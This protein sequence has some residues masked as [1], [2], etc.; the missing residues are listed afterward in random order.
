MK[1]IKSFNES[2]SHNFPDSK[3]EVDRLCEKYEI[4]VYTINDDLSIDVFGNV[5]LK[6]LNLPYIPLKFN[7]VTGTFNCSGNKLTSLEGTPREVGSSFACAQNKLTSLVGGPLRV[8]HN[9]Y[10]NDNKLTN[11]I[12]CAGDINMER[13][14][15]SIF[16][17]YNNI[18]SLE[19]CPTDI[20]LICC[21]HNPLFNLDY[22]PECHTT[23]LDMCPVNNL[24]Y[25]LT[26]FSK[27][28]FKTQNYIKQLS[29]KLEEFEVVK[30]ESLDLISLNSLFDYYNIPFDPN[31]FRKVTSYSVIE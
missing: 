11:L 12:G 7:K 2:Q 30:G 16:C 17:G 3:S 9:Y 24:I 27:T 23:D 18:S 6:R 13:F 20:H 8:G 4:N 10:C 14:E 15:M 21:P 29:D 1:Y 26:D 19:G 22:F 25:H 28:A 31:K 5:D